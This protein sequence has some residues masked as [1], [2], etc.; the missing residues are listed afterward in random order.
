MLVCMDAECLGSCT[1][2]LLASTAKS[3]PNS[4]FSFRNMASFPDTIA[5]TAQLVES[6]NQESARDPVTERKREVD[7]KMS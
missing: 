7:R 4:G 2:L 6:C 3:A 1:R 5:K